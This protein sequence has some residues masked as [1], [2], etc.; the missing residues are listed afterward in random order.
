MKT[1]FIIILFSTL[2]FGQRAEVKK[3]GKQSDSPLFTIYFDKKIEGQILNIKADFKS[4]D[5]AVAMTEKARIDN[6]T[7][8]IIE[9]DVIQNQTKEKAH[10]TIDSDKIKIKYEIEGQKPQEKEIK[11]P[12]YLVAPA[13]FE[14]W[15]EVHFETLKKEKVMHIQFLVWDRLETIGFKVTYL[16]ESEL[17]GQKVQQFKMNI[18]NMVLAIFISPIRIW[19]SQ[20]M[21]NLVRYEGRVAV[22]QVKG[23]GLEN[24]DAEVV[25]F[26][27]LKA[28]Q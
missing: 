13:N 16:G 12:D 9:Y 20:D 6:T 11:K 21:K 17:R 2:V 14:R 8:E 24:L 3:I 7:A 15:L 5:D 18:D 23:R 22:K 1:F 10:I 19:K 28:A 25:Y 4:Q 26:H 27:D